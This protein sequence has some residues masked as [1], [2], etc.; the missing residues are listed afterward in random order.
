MADALPPDPF[1]F[2][3]DGPNAGNRGRLLFSELVYAFADAGRA[4]DLHGAAAAIENGVASLSE[5]DLRYVVK[6][7]VGLVGAQQLGLDRRDD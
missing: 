6:F 1:P 3:A 5:E 4:N 2:D 7:A